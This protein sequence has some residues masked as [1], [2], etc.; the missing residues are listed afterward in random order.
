MCHA[1]SWGS[2]VH[3]LILSDSGFEKIAKNGGPTIP[4]NLVLIEKMQQVLK[5]YF[6]V[7]VHKLPSFSLSLIHI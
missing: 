7:M 3:P 6:K 2:V 4:L 5:M 1:I